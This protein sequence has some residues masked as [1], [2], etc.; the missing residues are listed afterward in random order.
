MIPALLAEADQQAKEAAA[1]QKE[2][3]PST[4]ARIAAVW[5]REGRTR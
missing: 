4:E 3:H 1:R 2:T 5:R